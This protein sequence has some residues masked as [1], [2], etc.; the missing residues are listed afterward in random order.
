MTTADETSSLHALAQPLD[1]GRRLV[2]ATSRQNVGQR[3]PFVGHTVEPRVLG[4]VAEAAAAV[5][6]PS[7]GLGGAPEHLEQARL[8]RTVAADETYLV[9]RRAQ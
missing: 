2:E 5:D 4:Q 8:A 6:D 3:H 9:A 7:E 1:P